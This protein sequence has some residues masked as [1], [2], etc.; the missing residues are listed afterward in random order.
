MFYTKTQSPF[1]EILITASQKGL[2]SLSFLAG[3]A[4]VTDLKGFEN[5]PLY[6]K[7]TLTQLAQYFDGERKTFNLALAPKGT[8]FQQYVWQTLTTINYG[9]TKSYRWLAEQIKNPKAVR[10]VGGANS[11]NPIALI[12]PCHRVIGSN[13]KLTGYAGGLTLKE[14]LLTF[15]GAI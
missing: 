9:D 14:Q 4:G 2:T 10:A 3:S 13:G 5:N 8:P 1:G 7:D 15:E 6:F 12:I 11:K